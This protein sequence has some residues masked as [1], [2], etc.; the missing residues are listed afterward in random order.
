VLRTIAPTADPAVLELVFR[1]GI[2]NVILAAFNLLPI[3]PLD[4]S[5]LIERVLPRRLLPQ[6]RTIRQYSMP[7]LLLIVLLIPGALGRVFGLAQTL[8]LQL[9]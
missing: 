5:A 7:V 9:L 8:W 4:G 6:W 1:F 2:I 3:P